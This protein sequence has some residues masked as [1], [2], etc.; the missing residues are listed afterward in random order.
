MIKRN[1]SFYISI[2]IDRYIAI[3]YKTFI[4]AILDIQFLIIVASNNNNIDK[5][6]L[7]EF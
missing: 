6:T 3:D 1:F 4:K 2:C 5:N 7:K